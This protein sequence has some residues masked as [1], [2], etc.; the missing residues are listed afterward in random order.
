MNTTKTAFSR[1]SPAERRERVALAIN[2]GKSNRAIGIEL[3]VD[4]GTVRRDRKF[5][6]TPETERPIRAPQSKKERPVRELSPDEH[7]RQR[8]HNLLVV[9]QRWITQ[10][11]LFLSDLELFVLPEADKRLYQ[12]SHSL[13]QLPEPFKSPDELLSLTRPT[14]AVEEYMPSKL[15]FYA[16]WLARWLAC[17]LPREEELQDEVLRQISVRARSS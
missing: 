3:G 11:H 12:H 9:V 4:E 16:D 8:L 6:E 15:E 10:E 5:L 14:Y 1:L 13:S 7:R 2:V 17:C